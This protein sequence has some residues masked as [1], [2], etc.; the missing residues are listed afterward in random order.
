[1]NIERMLTYILL[2]FIIWSGT[3][4]MVKQPEFPEYGDKTMQQGIDIVADF[5]LGSVLDNAPLEHYYDPVKRDPFI[6]FSHQKQLEVTGEPSDVEKIKKTLDF[7][8]KFTKEKPEKE[9]S[10]PEKKEKPEEEEPPPEKKAK[11]PKEILTLSDIPD[12]P[13]EPD[14]IP[15]PVSTEN[16]KKDES[17]PVYL[18]GFVKTSSEE[19]KERKAILSNK[20]TGELYTVQEGDSLL[21]MTIS[22]I[23]PFSIIIQ[24]E[25]G[26]RVEFLHDMLKEE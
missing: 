25:N 20:I 3:Y 6:P 5:D 2:A 16:V 8:W 19:E 21:G 4:I 15:E 17:I 26:R 22:Q 9:E 14:V 11:P 23:T 24:L 18:V 7:P 13:G 1:M 10:L 12:K